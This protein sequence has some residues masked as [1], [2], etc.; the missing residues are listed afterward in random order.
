MMPALRSHRCS[1]SKPGRRYGA[2]AT[3]GRPQ[4]SLRNAFLAGARQRVPDLGV[5]A[6]GR[7]L[8]LVYDYSARDD[9]ELVSEV[10]RS[11]DMVRSDPNHR[12]ELG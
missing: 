6:A 3:H 8:P 10:Y 5:P 9:H 11:A 12:T 4:R 1:G 7:D 2:L